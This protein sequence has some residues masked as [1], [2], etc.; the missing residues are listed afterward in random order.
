MSRS[1]TPA[2]QLRLLTVGRQIVHDRG[3]NACGVQDI[4]DAAGVSKSSFYSHFDS[5]DA[6]GLR[7]LE[8]YWQSIETKYGPILRDPSSTPR[9][10]IQQFF[11]A[12]SDDQLR[13][14]V[15][16]GCLIGNMSLELSNSNRDTRLK[17]SDVL[18]R[19]QAV[20]AECLRDAQEAG[21]LPKERDPEALAAIIIEAWEGAVMR[22]KVDQSD[23]PHGRFESV[24]LPILMS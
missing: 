5:K 24:V 2:V 9:S 23:A 22:A 11:R 12:L 3:F 10:R 15:A 20:I 18:D 19:W 16:R 17:L 7:I 1:P 21:E 14:T 4:A 13:Q 6:F 8:D